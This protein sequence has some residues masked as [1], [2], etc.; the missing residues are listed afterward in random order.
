MSLTST[1]AIIVEVFA[2]WAL[3]M[4]VMVILERRPPASTISWLLVL[5]FLPIVGWAIYQIIGPQRLKRLKIKRR[6]SSKLSKEASFALLDIDRIAP[7]RHR[8]QLARVAEQ[9]GESPPLRADTV[10]LYT[11]GDDAYAAIALAVAEATDHVH[12]EYYIWENDTT[13]QRFANQLL[14][15]AQAG[16]EVRIIVDGLGARSLRRKFFAPLIAAGAQVAWFNPVSLFALR[17]RRADLRTHRKIVICDGKVGFTGGMNIANCHSAAADGAK[18]WR[19]THVRMTGSVVRALQRVFNEDW[20]YTSKN[21]LPRNPTYFP[22]ETSTSGDVVQIISSGPD[23]DS[24]AIA[25]FIFAA[26]NQAVDRVW[27][28]T[29]YFVPNQAMLAALAST[30]LRGVDVRVLVPLRGDSKLVDLAA[31]S[32]F[33]E[34]LATG[35]KIYLFTPRFVHAKTMIIDDDVAMVGTANFDFRSFQLNFEVV[36]AIY[37]GNIPA[38]L[39]KAFEADTAQATWVSEYPPPKQRFVSRL[40]EASARLLSPL[41]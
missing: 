40:A 25:K 35:V 18:G 34:L 28:T 41:L 7:H 3:V 5:I 31:R 6:R 33:P 38:E 11:E 30:A 23:T 8:A 20:L 9:L 10:T 13:G 1:A 26:I 4:A 2:L 32:Y 36:A 19:D 22:S 14:Q 17:R 16:V 15:R 12:V 29:P 37:G 24:F 21:A 39:A 27:I